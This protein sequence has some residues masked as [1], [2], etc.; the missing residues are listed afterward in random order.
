MNPW[1]P[2]PI[3]FRALETC[4]DRGS[5]RRQSRARADARRGPG[6]GRRCAVQAGAAASGQMGG[7]AAARRAATAE[8]T[9]EGDHICIVGSE[10]HG[11]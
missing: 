9:A 7:A 6:T 2:E 1:D 10:F 5:T 3:E 11:F 8:G 4:E